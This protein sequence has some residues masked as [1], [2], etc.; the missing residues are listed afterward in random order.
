MQ[1]SV[2]ACF[3]STM[4]TQLRTVCFGSNCEYQYEDRNFMGSGSFGE[5]YK[6][7][8]T[9]RGNYVGPDVVAMR[10]FN[11]KEKKFVENREN[12]AKLQEGFETMLKLKHDHL[13]NYHKITII[14]TLGSVTV[15]FIMDYYRAG[16]LESELKKMKDSGILLNV[17]DA[18]CHALDLASGLAFLH[19]NGITH[20]DLKPSNVLI[21][22]SNAQRGTLRISD[23]DGLVTLQLCSVSS[24]NSEHFRSSERYMSPE[25]VR[26]I[27]PP[28]TLITWPTMPDS[29]TDVWSVGCVLLQLIR[30]ITGDYRETLQH[31]VSGKV[32]GASQSISDWVYGVAVMQGFVPVVFDAAAV[33]AELAACVRNCLRIA[34]N[35]RTSARQLLEH[36]SRISENSGP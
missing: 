14:P 27:G 12:Y 32:L 7:S 8:I 11:I 13:V 2:S 6:A 28:E 36:L 20:G 9:E 23:W 17:G 34:N 5:V 22:G 35:Q 26:A 3:R 21:D 25:M 24:L 30:A 29:S 18:I 1:R 15:N 19:E 4:S 16:N 33:P 10:C 31:P